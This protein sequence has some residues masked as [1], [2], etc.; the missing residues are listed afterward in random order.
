MAPPLDRRDLLCALAVASGAPTLLLPR[1]GRAESTEGTT[2]LRGIE[3]DAL[4][5]TLEL[6][7]TRGPFPHGGLPYTDD[8]TFVFVPAHHRGG[9]SVETVVHFHGHGTTARKTID[10]KQL[11]A[12]VHASGRNAILAVPQGPIDAKD[13]RWGRLDLADGLVAFLRELRRALQSVEVAGALGDAAIVGA[14]P[15]ALVISAH[16][17]GY[18]VA[19]SCL[20]RGGCNVN[21]V[22]L[23]DALYGVRDDFRSWVLARRDRHGARDRHK[24][25]AWYRVDSVAAQCAELRR[26]LLADGIAY[27]HVLIEREAEP[28]EMTRARVGFVRSSVGHRDVVHATDALRNALAWSC[29]AAAPAAAAAK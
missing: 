8:T 10:E 19:A 7:M 16:S 20:M 22:Y 17:G 26:E 9:R 14:R 18:R 2:V 1:R 6:G 28:A 29:L 13:S 11:R 12:Q 24:L 25:L 23:F 5:V 27:R 15:G 4:G 3:R 21:E